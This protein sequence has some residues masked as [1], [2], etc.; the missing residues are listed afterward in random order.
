ML[1]YTD[2]KKLNAVFNGISI[3]L[4]APEDWNSIGDTPTRDAVLSWIAAGNTPEL[5]T[6]P[7]SPLGDINYK[8]MI[9]RRAESLKKQ[10]QQYEAL[11][12]LQTIGD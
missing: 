11:L 4:A 6:P 2:S 1:K 7:V 10:G 9:R 3:S 5:A 12:L 8:A